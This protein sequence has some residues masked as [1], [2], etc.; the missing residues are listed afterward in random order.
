V[1]NRNSERSSIALNN[2]NA[3]RVIFEK[4]PIILQAVFNGSICESNFDAQY[5]RTPE[6][7]GQRILA[8]ID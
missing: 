7:T 8:W 4:L 2:K 5:Q 3:D 6:V 1:S